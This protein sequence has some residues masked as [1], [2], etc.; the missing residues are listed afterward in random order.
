MPYISLKA[1][2]NDLCVVVQRASASRSA[3]PGRL[4]I[5]A[6]TGT[7]VALCAGGGQASREVARSATLESGAMR[8]LAR[9]LALSAAPSSSFLQLATPM[10][11]LRSTIR[12]TAKL[13]AITAVPPHHDGDMDLLLCSSSSPT[14]NT[15]GKY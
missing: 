6:A 12:P 4:N 9:Y 14:I 10:T 7:R 2:H 3:G 8:P 1:L 5:T 11:V 13:E 15:M